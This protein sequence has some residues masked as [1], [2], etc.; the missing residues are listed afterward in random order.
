MAQYG[1]GAG[2][3]W[4]TPLTDAFGNPLANPSPILFGVLQNVSVDIS[5][6]IKELNGQ[7]QFAVAVGRGKGKIG[8]KASFAQINGAIINSLFFGQTMTSGILSDV[9][10]TT[11]APIPST[12]FA[13]TP[14]VPSSGTWTADLGVRDANGL[15]MT[16][17]AATPATGQYMVAAGVYTFAAADTGKTVFISYQYTAT[18]TVAKTS[19]VLNVPMGYAPKF[20]CDLFNGYSGKAL[21]LTLFA[22]VA[23]KLTLA[24]KLDDFMMPDFEASAF[25]DDSGRVLS[26]GTSE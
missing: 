26:W 9:Y 14:T 21:S 5:G 8:L 13:I 15:P 11:G 19:T 10:D 7:N 12:P 22:C 16:R 17:V 1:F 4:G 6:D 20:R 23:S 3:L 18:S 24:T 2:A 25:A